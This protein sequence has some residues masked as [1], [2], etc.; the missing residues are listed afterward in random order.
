[1]LTLSLRRL[2]AALGVSSVPAGHPLWCAT[3]AVRPHPREALSTTAW[4]P[5][6][7]GALQPEQ[8]LAATTSARR[9]AADVTSPRGWGGVGVRKGRRARPEELAKMLGTRGGAAVAVAAL[10]LLVGLPVDGKKLSST[11]DG[12]TH[13]NIVFVRYSIVQVL[14]RKSVS[15]LFLLLL[16][17]L[18][19]FHYPLPHNLPVATARAP[20]RST[21]LGQRRQREE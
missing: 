6:C 13:P 5:P 7:G 15:T 10:A 2:E 1:M 3:R 18:I 21:S 16:L 12:V 19:V 9:Q 4:L 20:T 11:S 8:R 17:L 14:S